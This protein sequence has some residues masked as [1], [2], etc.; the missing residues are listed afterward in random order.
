M[1]FNPF[2]LEG[3]TIL[4]TGASSGLGRAIAIQCS[5]MG[6]KVVITA[7]NAERLSDTFSMLIGEGHLLVRADITIEEDVERLAES[8]PTLDGCVHCAGIPQVK[9]LK[10]VNRKLLEDTLQ[11]NT[12]APIVITTSLL[13]KRKISKGGSVLFLASISGVTVGDP[14]IAAY[15]TSKGALTGFIKSAALALAPQGIRVNTISPGIVPTSM[16]ESTTDQSIS[17]NLEESVVTSYP[18]GRLGLPSDIA[19]GAIYLLSDASS[20]VTGINLTI[21]GGF[22]IP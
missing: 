21:D 8:C 13:K 22:S 4:V 14:G 10:F 1:M 20:W 17:E 11:I 19:N 16:F 9:A 5:K 6:A 12:I 15:A 3:K 18:L 2:S 7:R